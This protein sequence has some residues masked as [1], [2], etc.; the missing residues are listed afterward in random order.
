ML[1]RLLLAI[2]ALL[3]GS[4]AQAEPVVYDWFEYTGRDLVF[5]QPLPPGHY[6]NPILSGFYPDPSIT[7]AGDRFYL[8]HSTFAYFPGI[9]VFEVAIWSIGGRSATSSIDRR[10]STSA[11][12][13]CRAACLRRAS[14]I[15]TACSMS[16]TRWWTAAA[17]TS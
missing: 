7:R 17:T 10:N 14:S 13:A 1:R 12:S 4:F 15:A 5:E 9:P 6:R 3:V 8:V 2:A 11:S 16:S